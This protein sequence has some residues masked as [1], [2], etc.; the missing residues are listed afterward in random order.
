M[1]KQLFVGVCA[2]VERQPAIHQARISGGPRRASR[3]KL[4]PPPG[5][6]TPNPPALSPWQSPR[7]SRAR[8]GFHPSM[9]DLL[10]VFAQP[11]LLSLLPWRLTRQ[12]RNMPAV[13]GVPGRMRPLRWLPSRRVVY[14][15]TGRHSR[16]ANPQTKHWCENCAFQANYFHAPVPD[17][18]DSN[19]AT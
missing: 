16:P 12:R 8:I 6:F 15:V 13:R 19:L 5:A 3:R 11:L 4:Y 10:I 2:N 7:P 9:P 18:N 17:S 14:R 1:T